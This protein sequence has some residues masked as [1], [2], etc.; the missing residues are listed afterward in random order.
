M[1][2]LRALLLLKVVAGTAL[3]LFSSTSMSQ[4]SSPNTSAKR[5]AAGRQPSFADVS[6]IAKW[7]DD[8]IKDRHPFNYPTDR[9]VKAMQKDVLVTD[10]YQK[11]F[12]SGDGVR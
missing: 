1:S 3:A 7:L 12:R 2:V 8:F 10:K 9:A 6:K 11:L 5:P 4:R